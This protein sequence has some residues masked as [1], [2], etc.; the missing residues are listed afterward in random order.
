MLK[1]KL[2][3]ALFIASPSAWS[4]ALF[5]TPTGVYKPITLKPIQ[6]YK[7]APVFKQTTPGK[8]DNNALRK[9]LQTTAVQIK[10]NVK[11]KPFTNLTTKSYRQIL[12]LKGGSSVPK[13][14]KEKILDALN[15][16]V[17]R[18]QK[19]VEKGK[20]EGV[21]V[22]GGP[23]NDKTTPIYVQIQGQRDLSIMTVYD[24]KVLRDMGVKAYSQGLVKLN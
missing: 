1:P 24:L 21:A 6:I 19:A 2:L 13:K 7:P 4:L 14:T 18:G 9:H 5:N 16:G 8:L 12:G 23:S 22:A 17:K 20:S 3:L 11:V 15:A 10:K